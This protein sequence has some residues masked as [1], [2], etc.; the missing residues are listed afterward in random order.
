MSVEKATEQINAWI[1]EINAA[2]GV[3]YVEQ[4][5]VNSSYDPTKPPGPDNQAFT[6]NP[7]YDP[8]QPTTV[9]DETGALENFPYQTEQVPVNGAFSCERLQE[10]VDEYVQQITDGIA[11]G[12]QSIANIM[13]DWAPL[14][15]LPSDPLKIL[16]WAS[17]VVGGPIATQIAL[18]TEI[19]IDIAQLASAIAN[20]ISAITSAIAK[21]LSCLETTIFN[22]FNTVINSIYQNAANLIATAELMVDNIIANALDA[23]GAS[24]LL[25]QIDAIGDDLGAAEDAMITAIGDA[26]AAKASI[27]AVGQAQD[28]LAASIALDSLS[29]QTRIDRGLSDVD[30]VPIVPS[31]GGG[32]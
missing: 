32:G 30:G 25:D 23:T 28:Q 24:D 11:S 2:T 27:D 9:N 26:V 10:I 17:K 8:S 1:D 15:S 20:L 18:I 13:S 29:L 14:L 31:A 12:A 22:A 6:P 19:I 16:T 4:A 5:A 3:T 21:L 7:S